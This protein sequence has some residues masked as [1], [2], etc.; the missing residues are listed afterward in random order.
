MSQVEAVPSQIKRERKKQ[1]AL[2]IDQT[3]LN[4]TALAILV[5]GPF[6]VT[7]FQIDDHYAAEIPLLL[8]VIFCLFITK[9]PISAAFFE[10]VSSIL[11]NSSILLVPFALLGLIRGASFADVYGDT[12]AIFCVIASFAILFNIPANIAER[13]VFIAS[14][15]TLLLYVFVFAAGL[16]A[17]FIE[18]DA[19]LTGKITYPVILFVVTAFYLMRRHK[20]LAFISLVGFAYLA[21]KTSYRYLYIGLVLTVAGVVLVPLYGSK[22]LSDEVKLLTSAILVG[23]AG[24]LLK[25]KPITILA[26]LNKL[27]LFALSQGLPIE[28]IKQLILKFV[29][30]LYNQSGPGDAIYIN[31]FH[32]LLDIPRFAVPHGIGHLAS[33]GSPVIFGGNT[34]DNTI[35]FLNY[36]FSIWLTLAIFAFLA[37]KYWQKTRGARWFVHVQMAFLL[38]P[39]AFLIYIR[40]VPFATVSGGI[41]LGF[42]A[43]ILDNFCSHSRQHG[44]L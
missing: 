5:L 19:L 6:S 41:S 8:F 37:R 42:I 13:F 10:R 2:A 1:F 24:F 36:H 38:A 4:A 12:R 16:S 28:Y 3:F 40:A 23:G 14:T 26:Y 11:I 33:L 18:S 29:R 20:F 32:S 9:T 43:V 44:N 15:I 39:V 30:A 17:Q 34:I 22:R 7:M 27:V 25:T 31:Y 21:T 35:I